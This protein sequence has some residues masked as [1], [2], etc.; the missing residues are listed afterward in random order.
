MVWMF[1]TAVETAVSPEATPSIQGVALIGTPLRLPMRLRV[2]VASHDGLKITK[3]SEALISFVI[4]L[5]LDGPAHPRWCGYP[6][7]QSHGKQNDS[8]CGNTFLIGDDDATT[9][10]KTGD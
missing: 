4:A 2:F 9:F 3:T 7:L 5:R 8:P 1:C 10:G 6:T